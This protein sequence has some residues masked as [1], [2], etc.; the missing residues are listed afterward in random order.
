[1]TLANS[2]ESKK[3]TALCVMKGKF[4]FIVLE[5]NAQKTQQCLHFDIVSNI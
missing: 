4:F 3:T 1:M 2:H 5:T